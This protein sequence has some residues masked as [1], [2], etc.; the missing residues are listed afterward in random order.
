[1]NYFA[2]FIVPVTGLKP[3]SHQFD[4]E[5]DD[6]FFEHFEYSE[7][8]QGKIHLNLVVEKE[9]NLLVFHFDFKGQVRVPCDRCYEL[10]DQP[11]GGRDRLIIKFGSDFHEESEDV[12]VVPIGENHFDI[13]PF[14]YEYIHLSLPVRRVHPE[15]DL[16]ENR[17]EAEMIH[18]LEELA[19]SSEPDPRWEVLSQLKKNR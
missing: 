1:M 17:C 16:G 11:I 2:Q 14:V 19:T 8:R 18:R 7:I 5:I 3:G 6:S 13:S 9:E 10:F 12:Q 4:F 15:D